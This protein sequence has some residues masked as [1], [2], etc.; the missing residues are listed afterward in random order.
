MSIARFRFNATSIFA[1][2][3]ARSNFDFENTIHYRVSAREARNSLER[4]RRTRQVNSR[5]DLNL[6]FFPYEL[7]GA[8][9]FAARV[10]FR[11]G[12]SR[13]NRKPRGSVRGKGQTS[14]RQCSLSP[15]DIHLAAR[16]EYRYSSSLHF[17]AEHRL[18]A[19]ARSLVRTITLVG[20]L[21]RIPFSIYLNVPRYFAQKIRQRLHER[22]GLRYGLNT[23]FL[24]Q[25]RTQLMI[26]QVNL[27][28]ENS[29]EINPLI[30][31]SV[32]TVLKVSLS[33]LGRKAV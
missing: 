2:T 3:R 24:T 28:W 14:F 17:L 16:E 6:F 10:L 5:D 9:V 22:R 8:S 15:R 32:R 20:I 25:V 11:A 31:K 12:G 13:K 1:A 27:F 21:Q 26:Q 30:G 4:R 29:Q 23:C 7:K 19:D 18:R 33:T